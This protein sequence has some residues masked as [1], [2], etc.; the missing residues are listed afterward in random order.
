[1]GKKKKGLVSNGIE[2]LFILFIG[3]G[4][5][6]R[7]R[8]NPF[9]TMSMDLSKE[10]IQEAI[11]QRKQKLEELKAKRALRQQQELDKKGRASDPAAITPISSSL[12]SVSSKTHRHIFI[13]T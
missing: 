5:V 7:L 8:R 13:N 4:A 3:T 12:E 6:N 10:G 1:M 11:E 2:T 9:T